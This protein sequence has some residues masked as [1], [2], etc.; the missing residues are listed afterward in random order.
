MPPTPLVRLSTEPTLQR[1]KNAVFLLQIL[2]TAVFF[3]FCTGRLSPLYPPQNQISSPP[4]TK[5]LVAP[6]Y[7][8]S[9]KV[10]VQCLN[11]CSLHWSKIF[12]S[13]VCQFSID[14]VIYLLILSKLHQHKPVYTLSAHKAILSSHSLK[15]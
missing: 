2:K 10:Y 13:F 8:I 1:L 14:I 4:L 12:T 6:L 7:P 9:G 15:F 11:T 5:V 3:K